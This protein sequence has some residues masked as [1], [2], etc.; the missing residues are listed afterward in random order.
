[1][2]DKLRSD[3]FVLLAAG[4]I[5]LL[6]PLLA[7]KIASSRL[8]GDVEPTLS[9]ALG[10]PVTIGGVEASLSGSVRLTDVEV[11]GLVSASAVE[12]SV[13]LD[14]LL[15]GHLGADEIRIESPR[16]RTRID[17]TGEQRLRRL[18]QRGIAARRRA[19]HGSRSPGAEGPSRLRRILVT[20]G[21]LR[22]DLEGRGTIVLSDVALHPHAHGVR[23]VAGEV[24]FDMFDDGL[25][26]RARFER[27]AADIGIPNLDLERALAVGGEISVTG[28][29]VGSI[30]LIDAVASKG[31][32][33]A[34]RVE[35]TAAVAG[36]P[37]ARIT[38]TADADSITVEGSRIPLGP[39][40]PYLPH[41]LALAGALGTGR[42]EL[43]RLTDARFA[44]TTDIVLEGASLT[45]PKLAALPLPLEGR[46]IVRA[47][48][49]LS[50]DGVGV[51]LQEA[52]FETGGASVTASGAAA[53]SAGD[54]LPVRADLRVSVPRTACMTVLRAIP[55]PARQRLAGLSG[56]GTMK[57]E[58]ALSFDRA[59]PGATVLDV[60]VDLSKCKVQ[61]EATA[62]NPRSLRK[63]FV[64]TF[65]DGS[66]AT[67][68]PGRE[69]YARIQTIPNLVTGAF[70][71]AE[72]ARFWK[73][74]GFD[75]RQIAASLS[76]DLSERKLL[77]GGSTIT[78]QLAKNVFL[79]PRRTFARKLEE[80][81]LAWRLESRLGK[82]EILEVYL[83]II[84]L[85]DGVFGLKPAARYWF[86]K[87]I[88]RLSV[89]EV[90]FLAA[91]T[92]AP[93]TISQRVRATGKVDKE[94][95]H[96]VDIVLR[97]MRR[98]GVISMAAYQRAKAARL[99]IRAPRL[100][101]R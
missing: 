43:R 40:A 58:V 30:R 90:A 12:A 79:D 61:R 65:P 50:G 75:T 72:D 55:A 37:L 38:L 15:S 89:R 77:R 92:P 42:A 53:F 20:D 32:D 44:V 60:D 85:G 97:H 73:H 59:D 66:S 8:H 67:V 54:L 46:A 95:N 69:S 68:G 10:E 3:G 21:H 82:R 101:S 27:A 5:A 33:T 87:E 39:L 70:V 98:A 24:L 86:D 9:A 80:A 7:A 99:V 94:T 16:L 18:M 13:G 11:G 1:M 56:T 52:R 74:D 14:S 36:D 64:H 63:P 45:H 6:V 91:L 17:R 93:R 22:V 23:A 83:N 2:R 51:E 47:L 49:D 19:T 84:E 81:V 35:L 62:G 28:P 4:A 57:A 96:R 48:V 88:R 31:I 76:I 26:M 25:Y 71:A 78:Q 100:A 34:S 29:R 41:A